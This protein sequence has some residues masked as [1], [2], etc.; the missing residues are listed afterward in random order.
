MNVSASI[1]RPVFVKALP[2]FKPLI[3]SPLSKISISVT[4]KVICSSLL[5]KEKK[6]LLI[7]ISIIIFEILFFINL[8][9][10]KTVNY[11]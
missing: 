9:N 5:E 8:K 2:F 1:S 4:S 10:H 7:S 11:K 6:R 3:V